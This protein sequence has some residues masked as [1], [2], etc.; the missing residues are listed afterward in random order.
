MMARTVHGGAGWR[1]ELKGS[2][3]LRREMVNHSCVRLDP[4]GV[5]NAHDK[6]EAAMF[7]RIAQMVRG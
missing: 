3:L 4:L 5:F 2:R 6:K 7:G 1:H